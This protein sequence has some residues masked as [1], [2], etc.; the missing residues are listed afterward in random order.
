MSEIIEITININGL[1]IKLSPD[2]CRELRNEL[3][4]VVGDIHYIPNQNPLNLPLI[5]SGTR[6]SPYPF[7][8][9]TCEISEVDVGRFNKDKTSWDIGITEDLVDN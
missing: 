2:E 9:I 7:P 8:T 1:E 4:K 6:N 3:N 5:G